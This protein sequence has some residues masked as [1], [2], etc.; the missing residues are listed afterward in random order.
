[1]KT[2]KDKYLVV[3][4][5]FAGFPLKEVVVEHL[6]KKG[7]KILDLGVKKDS[8][9]KDTDLMFHRVGLRVGAEISEGNYERALL[10]CGTG[11]GIHIAASKCPHVHAGVVESLPAA[12]RAITGNGV[13]V[14][15]MGAFYVAPQTACDIAD[16]YL[17]NS[18]GSGWEWWHNFYE[19]HKLAIDELEAFDY[20]KYKEN[21]FK[22]N[23][24]GDYP[25]K[26]ETKPE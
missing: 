11:M 20:E 19:F 23:K 4:A 7:W 18:L 15:A 8:D 26:L 13:N 3:G 6:E 25:L 16:A 14:L 5:D 10:F 9:P 22:V 21:G 12:T 24:P 1:M 17:S 2:V